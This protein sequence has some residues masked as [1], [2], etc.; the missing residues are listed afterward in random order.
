MPRM[1]GN[2]SA[3]ARSGHVKRV[4]GCRR[5]HPIPGRRAVYLI[6]LP[7]EGAVQPSG[8]EEGGSAQSILVDPSWS[9]L[10]K[11]VQFVSV[12]HQSSHCR[13]VKC[14]KLIQVLLRWS[15]FNVIDSLHPSLMPQL[16]LASVPSNAH[17]C[18]I[19]ATANPKQLS[20]QPELP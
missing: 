9:F 5:A 15:I 19:S 13:S 8:A 18:T 7:R 20:K 14:D 12:S 11:S 1:R 16:P 17:L 4:A 6:S 3:K 10:K 2:R